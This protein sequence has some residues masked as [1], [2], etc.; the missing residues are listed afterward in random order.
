MFQ[1]FIARLAPNARH[2]AINVIPPLITFLILL[3]VWQLAF[4]RA[5]STLPP[6]SK[7]WSEARDLI[8]D[9]FF[10]AGPQDIGL[11]WRVLTSLQ[12]VAEGFGLAAIVGVLTG[13]LIGQSVWAMRGLDPIFQVLRTVPPLAW[14][15]IALAAF[16]DSQPSAIF[17]IFITAIWPIIINT[18]VGIRNIPQDYRNVARVVQL[19]QVEFFFKIMAPSAAPKRSSRSWSSTSSA[20]QWGPPSANDSGMP[21]AISICPCEKG[22]ISSMATRCASIQSRSRVSMGRCFATIEGAWLSPSMATMRRTCAGNS[23]A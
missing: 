6:P 22:G 7:V 23:A 18:A 2:V 10:V 8:T 3:L 21:A 17:V 13:A 12:R 15:P 4:G 9:P 14:L 19:N 5:G 1:S 16:R 20:G 11:G